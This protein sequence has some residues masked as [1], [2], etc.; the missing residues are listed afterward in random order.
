MNMQGDPNERCVRPLGSVLGQ[1]PQT[2]FTDNRVD[3]QMILLAK[4]TDGMK[5]MALIRDF[6]YPCRC[7][8]TPGIPST[9]HG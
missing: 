8:S 7:Q 3:K 5:A 1:S 6:I 4:L 2:V 9:Q